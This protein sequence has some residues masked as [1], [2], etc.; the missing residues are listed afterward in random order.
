MGT[1]GK[2][3]VLMGVDGSGKST[4][5]A[6]LRRRC[7]KNGI[8]L[9]RLHWRPYLLPSPRRFYGGT[10]TYDVSNPHANKEHGTVISLVLLLYYFLDFWLGYLFVVRPCRERG[11]FVLFERYYYD[12]LCDPRRYR[13]K[14]L[15]LSTWLTRFIPKPDALFVLYGDPL[16]LHKRKQELDVEEIQRQQLLLQR[17]LA[18]WQSVCWLDVE[19]LS[20]EQVADAVFDVL[21]LG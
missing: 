10:P 16:I 13:L 21:S 17:R 7:A 14:P 9:V 3:I 19:T 2:F 1:E 12:V 11:A 20:P 4:V 8:T 5:T 15:R 6:E 18:E